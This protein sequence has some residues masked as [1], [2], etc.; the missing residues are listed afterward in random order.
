MTQ[1]SADWRNPISVRVVIRRY[2]TGE[3]PHM[4]RLDQL[5][6]PAY[7]DLVP[8]C[9]EDYFFPAL[10]P[11]DMLSVA[12]LSAPGEVCSGCQEWGRATPHSVVVRGAV[13]AVGSA[14]RR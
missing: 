14:P 4:Y 8:C 11:R 7:T 2:A 6:D 12:S 3:L 10:H 9:T 13:T 1:R 5:D